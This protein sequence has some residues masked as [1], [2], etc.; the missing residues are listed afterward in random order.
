[1]KI[2]SNRIL[3]VLFPFVLLVTSS[4]DLVDGIN[5]FS[6][7]DDVLLGSQID[8]EIRN[9]PAEYPI[10]NADPTVK[11]YIKDRIFYHLLSSS[12]IENKNIFNYQLEIIDIDSI[13]NAFA[14]P[15]GYIYIYTGL[16]RYL[17]SESALAG[18]IGHE[19]AH[20]ERRHAT[21]RLTAYYGVSILLGIVLGENPSTIAEIAANLFVG[22]TFLANSRSDE[23]ES[24]K[25]SF[26]YL[27]DTR[28]YPGSVK[29]FFEKMQFEGLIDSSSSSIETFLST[30]P[31]P[32]QRIGN[33]NQLLQNEGIPI[34]N[35]QSN[36]VDM[37][38]NEYFINIRNKL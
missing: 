12:Q 23:E 24:D 35:F 28:Y 16:L 27:K 31:D 30:H 5:I 8:E 14:G 2:N 9:N 19:I 34:K 32:I 38:R 22:L 15:G 4:C 1:M 29:F 20:A 37:Y 25:Y 6:K 13:L 10:Y 3:L 36:D 7:E 26:Q 33:I 18:V 17:D 11:Q 21:Q